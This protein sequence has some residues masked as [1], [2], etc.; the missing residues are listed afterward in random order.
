MQ[1][2]VNQMRY[3]PAREWHAQPPRVSFR[4]R[5]IWTDRVSAS[6]FCAAYQS[7]CLPESVVSSNFASGPLH[8]KQ[9]AGSWRLP[10]WCV[11]RVALRSAKVCL[12][13]WAQAARLSQPV[14]RR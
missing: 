12:L 8:L 5:R 7:P 2:M 11:P 6:R 3:A 13:E 10:V 9:L 1:S 4:A 14:I